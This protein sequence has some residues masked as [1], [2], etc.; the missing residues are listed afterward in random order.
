MA[1]WI[2]D[3]RKEIESN[4]WLM[5]PMYH[6][7]WQLIKY[8][9]NHSEAQ[10]PNKDGSFT[11]IFPGQMA[12]SYRLLAQKVGYYE[13]RKWKEPNSKTVKS[14]I[15]WLVKQNMISVCSNTLGTIITVENWALYQEKEE[16]GNTKRTSLPTREKHH[17]D[18]NNNDKEELKNDKKEQSFKFADKFNSD[19]FK[20][21]KYLIN[22]MLRN[23]PN[24]KVPKPETTKF[25]NWCVNIDRM[26]RLDNR[27]V[28]EIKHII[29][30]SQNSDFWRSNILSTSK[31]REKA[32][33]L[34]LQSQNEALKNNKSDPMMDALKEMLANE[35]SGNN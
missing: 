35:Q 2:K 28:D 27:E 11:K 17:L 13:G 22:Y 23:D 20:L 8:S 6:R 14:I 9:V 21:T 3:Y 18:T 34:L 7:V 29:E 12:T 10:I 24:A 25:D 33:T 26:I 15:D 30:F 4:I 32:G 19:E 31:L 5:P 16:Q 1:G